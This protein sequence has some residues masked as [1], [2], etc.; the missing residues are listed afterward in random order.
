MSRDIAKLL[1]DGK[2]RSAE[3]IARALK[4]DVGQV[5][6]CISRMSAHSYMQ[7]LPKQYKLNPKGKEYAA[8]PEYDV[9]RR[10]KAQA[11]FQERKKVQQAKA[12]EPTASIVE[13]AIA[14]RHALH[15]VWG[16]AN[17]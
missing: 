3:A 7:A 1:C 13:K 16:A 17:A 14:G 12:A 6:S 11:D 15:S 10:Q 9:V 2:P 4:L 5:R 8:S